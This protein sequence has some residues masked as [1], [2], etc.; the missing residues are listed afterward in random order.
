[1]RPAPPPN[2]MKC[3]G[4]PS[5]K[6]T[7]ARPARSTEMVVPLRADP[8]RLADRIEHLHRRLGARAARNGAD[9]RGFGTRAFRRREHIGASAPRRREAH[10]VI[11]AAGEERARRDVALLG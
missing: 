4:C 9:D 7:P 1:M 3:A 5:T 2:A 10:L 6:R 8:E 11:V